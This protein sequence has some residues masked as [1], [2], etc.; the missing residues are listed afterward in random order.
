[1]AAKKKFEVVPSLPTQKDTGLEELLA[2]RL[3]DDLM[4]EVD[5]G[6]LAKLMFVHM[7]KKLRTKAIEWLSA[8]TSAP[9]ALNEVEAIAT[10]VEDKAA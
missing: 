4:A 5:M 10:A 1:M 6:K 7:G 9:I 2:P 8:D 3:A